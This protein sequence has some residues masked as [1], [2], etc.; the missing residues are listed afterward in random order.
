MAYDIDTW[1]HMFE[2]KP[3]HKCPV[4]GA[5]CEAEWVDIGFGSY[6]Q[7][8]GPWHCE[9]GWVDECPY[10]DPNKCKSCL[11]ERTCFSPVKG[12]I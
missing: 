12:I 8:A 9:C 4:C 11:N 5:D 1:V 7:Q 3:E 6:S 2:D 10:V